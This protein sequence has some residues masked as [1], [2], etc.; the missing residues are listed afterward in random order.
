MEESA[1]IQC[2]P[3]RVDENTYKFRSGTS[4]K[5]IVGGE[6]AGREARK[7][8][9]C[10]SISLRAA[11]GDITGYIIHWRPPST[12]TQLEYSHREDWTGKVWV[13]SERRGVGVP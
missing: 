9:V 5:Y 8:N 2:P 7:S 12:A 13:V 10:V 4:R 1:A 6:L 11:A 3:N